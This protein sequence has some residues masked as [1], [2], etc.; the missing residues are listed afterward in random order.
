MFF[1]IRMTEFIGKETITD[2]LNFKVWLLVIK[3]SIKT[4]HGCYKLRSE[5]KN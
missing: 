4:K 1:T 5:L 3:A 2:G